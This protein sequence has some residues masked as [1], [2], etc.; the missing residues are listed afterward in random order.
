MTSA[1][2]IRTARLIAALVFLAGIVWGVL[3]VR[4]DTLLADVDCGSV[5]VKPRAG[6]PVCASKLSDRR[7][8]VYVLIIAGIA[9]FVGAPMVLDESKRWHG[10]AVE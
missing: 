5:L 9:G 8:V 2:R 1:D 3:P 6:V 10:G 4:A 7:P